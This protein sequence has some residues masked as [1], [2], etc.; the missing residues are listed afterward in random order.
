MEEEKTKGS[1][2]KAKTRT[3]R[4]EIFT[5]EKS[6]L[7]YALKLYDVRSSMI[8]AFTNNNIYSGDVQRDAY[9]WDLHINQ[10]LKKV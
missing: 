4:K 2:K 5:A 7:K 3:Q 9:Y 6:V 10:N 1:I 8:N